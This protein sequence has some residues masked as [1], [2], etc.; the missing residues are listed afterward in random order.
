VHCWNRSGRN[1]QFAHGQWKHTR[2]ILFIS[3]HEFEDLG[4]M[5]VMEW[6]S[7]GHSREC[8]D[9]AI[10][11]PCLKGDILNAAAPWGRHFARPIY[12]WHWP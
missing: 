9:H 3:S 4:S 10:R 6:M 1:S 2:Y 12:A 11:I 5:T 8:R 7:S